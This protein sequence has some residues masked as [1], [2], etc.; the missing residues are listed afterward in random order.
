MKV[1][2]ER[3]SIGFS[4]S[5]PRVRVLLALLF[6]LPLLLA[7]LSSC[8]LTRRPPT[9]PSAKGPVY[10]EVGYASW[11]G[12]EFDGRPTS[13][14]EIYDMHALTAAH[15][16]LPM[17]TVAEVT[18]LGNGRSV[19][20]KINDRGPFVGNR[21]I[22]L[23]Y[24]AAIQIEMADQGVAKVR[25]VAW[26]KEVDLSS[27]RFTIQV[28][29]FLIEENAK[30]FKAKMEPYGPASISLYQTNRRQYYRVRVGD[31]REETGA[32]DLARKLM[33]EGLSP[34]VICAD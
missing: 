10:Q 20:L 6:S 8:A 4:F 30:R 27:R 15:R 5:S 18:H 23:S 21:I 17:G 2:L 33:K 16:T 22:D 14:G 19:R 25:L 1:R 11:Y 3:G 32:Q 12:K 34:L 13:S 7:F 28:G 26:P 9:P 24:E 31:F 29:S